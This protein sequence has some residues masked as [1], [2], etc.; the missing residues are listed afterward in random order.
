MWAEREGRGREG[1]RVRFQLWPELPL[2]FSHTYFHISPLLLSELMPG[3]FLP[4]LYPGSRRLAFP[5]VRGICPPP[6]GNCSVGGTSVL[7]Q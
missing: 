5:L 6:Q 3:S 2:V 7:S 4:C 1:E